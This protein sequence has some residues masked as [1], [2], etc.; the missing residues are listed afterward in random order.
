[1]SFAPST[2]VYYDAAATT[3][4]A[5]KCSSSLAPYC[6]ITVGANSTCTLAPQI[7]RF[8]GE[9]CALTSDCTLGSTCTNSRCEAKIL[10]SPCTTDLDCNV[11]LYCNSNFLCVK[12]I[13]AMDNGCFNDYQCVNTAGCNVTAVGVNGGTCIGYFNVSDYEYIATCN[14]NQSQ[15]CSTGYCVNYEG[16]NRCF[17]NAQ[18]NKVY[19]Y[20]CEDDCRSF[21]DP[22]LGD[23]YL[24]GLCNCGYNPE[25]VT[26]CSLFYQDEEAQRFFSLWND[27]ATGTDIKKCH[28]LGR[29][30]FECMKEH[31]G[32]YEEYTYKYYKVQNYP[33]HYFA[34]DCV[35]EVFLPEYYYAKNVYEGAVG[36]FLGIL[37]VNLF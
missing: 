1:M 11:G 30:S 31:W 9:K 27:W 35:L 19:P 29:N 14:N 28:T 17:G 32:S 23:T 12:L 4:Y 10:L 33:Y 3:H 18:N 20:N 21:S 34:D 7:L 37:V 22:N 15:L 2:C 26:V 16:S 13:E 24:P 5:E 36:T 25:R 6:N 8:P